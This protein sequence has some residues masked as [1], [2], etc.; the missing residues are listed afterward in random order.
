MAPTAP[1]AAKKTTI[2]ALAARL[3]SAMH[4]E[5]KVVTAV[6]TQPQVNQGQW[7]LEAPLA[8]RAPPPIRARP[9]S[10]ALERLAVLE[11]LVPIRVKGHRVK[12]AQ[13]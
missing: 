12:A 10:V 2:Q 3:P 13:I 7:D 9:L 11:A 8:A 6:P 4:L 5:A 1:K